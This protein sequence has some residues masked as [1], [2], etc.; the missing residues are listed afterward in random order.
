M[1]KVLKNSGYHYWDTLAGKSRAHSEDLWRAH[2]KWVY[3]NLIERWGKGSNCRLALKT[4]LYDE[5]VSTHNLIPLLKDKC[6]YTIGM[7]ISFEVAGQAK[8]QIGEELSGSCK[9]VV[10]DT[11]NLAFK[12]STFDKILSNSTLDHFTHKKEIIESLKELCRILRP[13]GTLIITL[14]NPWNPVVF[15]RNFLPYR[16]LKMLGVIPFYMGI[17]LS[18]P[19]LVSILESNGFRILDSTAIVHCPRILAIW[20]GKIVGMVGS[21]KTRIYFHRLLRK[22]ELLEDFPLRYFTGY[23]VAVKAVR[24]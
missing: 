21:E 15:L 12:T 11:R 23:Y 4:D 1:K 22:F 18:R 16:F 17:T 13:G 24:T 2:M 8:Q 9:I 10:S 7:D 3:K 5:A 19:E 6:E 20:I 14:D